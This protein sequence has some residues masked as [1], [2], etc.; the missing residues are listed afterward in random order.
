MRFTKA[1]AAALVALP[2]TLA[3]TYTDCNPMEK[4]CPKDVGLNSANFVSN[5]ASDPNAEDSWSKAAYTTITY[6]N[7]GAQFR[8]ASQGQAPTIA[9]NFYFFFGRVDVTMKSASGQ[10]IVSSIVLESDDLDAAQRAMAATDVNRRWQAEMAPY[11]A[12]IDGAPDE[13]FVRL[14]EVFHLETQLESHPQTAEG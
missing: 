11:F 12:E 8:I 1:A 14:T 2:T 4:T 5:F 6:D 7:Q 10:G 9:T 3:Q 13:G